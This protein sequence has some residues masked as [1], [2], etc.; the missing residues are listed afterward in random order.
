MRPSRCPGAPPRRWTLATAVPCE[1]FAPVF[2]PCTLEELPENRLALERGEV[3]VDAGIQNAGGLAL[4][5]LCVGAEQQFQVRIGPV[6]VDRLQAPLVP[7][8]LR[9]R[10]AA[11]ETGRLRFE[12]GFGQASP[13]L[14]LHARRRS[15]R[16]RHLH[17]RPRARTAAPAGRRERQSRRKGDDS[18][19]DHPKE[20]RPPGPAK[21]PAGHD[22]PPME[23][24]PRLSDEVTRNTPDS[25]LIQRRRN[26]FNSFL[27]VFEGRPIADDDILSIGYAREPGIVYRSQERP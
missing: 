14:G 23:Q 15:R 18:A 9:V 10:K 3:A 1:E 16:R 20:T 24:T 21:Q 25:V 4:A 5:G 2:V 12:F 26:C 22:S 13:L 8:A 27:F 17:G 11:H 7:E 6:E 19:E